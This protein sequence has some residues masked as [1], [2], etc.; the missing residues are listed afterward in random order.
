MAKD[1]EKEAAATK[2]LDYI[3]DGYVVGLGSGSTAAIMIRL[4]GR[5]VAEGLR[6]T[7]IPS[8][9][10]TKELAESHG[11]KV[12]NLSEVGHIDVNIDGAD[13]FDEQLRLI[14]GGGGA[15]LHEKIV[16]SASSR[17]IIIA[18]SSKFTQ[19]LNQAYRLPIETIP[20]ASDLIAERLEKAEF[21]PRRRKNGRHSFLT[22]EGNHIIDLDIGHFRDLDDLDRQLHAI[23]GVVETGLFLNYTHLVIMGEGSGTR[24]FERKAGMMG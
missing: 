4:L 8:S 7:G 10:A 5:R 23:P 9:A 16:A 19:Y 3:K 12:K 15:L 22:Q 2:A 18:D 6:I 1:T 11:I 17:N 21:S 14:K 13:A 24:I 20:M